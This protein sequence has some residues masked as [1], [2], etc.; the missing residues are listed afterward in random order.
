[1]SVLE[2]YE[3]TPAIVVLYRPFNRVSA[4]DCRQWVLEQSTS[5][6]PALGDGL[7]HIKTSS[8]ELKLLLLYLKLNASLVHADYPIDKKPNE[9]RFKPSVILPIAPLDFDALAKIVHNLGCSVCGKRGASR[10][11]R[12]QT[13][14]YCGPGEHTN[15]QECA[16]KS[17]RADNVDDLRRV[18]ARR[19]AGPQA[20]VQVAQ[21]RPLGPDYLPNFVPGRRLDE[22]EVH[23]EHQQVQQR[24]V[25]AF[26]RDARAQEHR[27]RPARCLGRQGVHDQVPGASYVRRAGPYHDLRPEM[28]LPSLRAEK[29]Q[30]GFRGLLRGDVEPARWLSG[31]EDVP[32]GEEDGRVGAERVLGSAAADGYAV[33]NA[34]TSY[35]MEAW[36]SALRCRNL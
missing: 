2:I 8:L 19:L 21:G 25:W 28:L 9:A 12:C 5:N 31:V 1:M 36:R 14:W 33:V 32:V 11:A 26:Y 24:L 22:I 17:A 6:A 16:H 13:V 3:D 30:P 29:E 10:C 35:E 27:P 23:D 18:S 34:C 7:I 20:V 4:N 15:W